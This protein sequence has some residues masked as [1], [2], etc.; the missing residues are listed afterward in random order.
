MHEDPRPSRRNSLNRLALV[1]LAAA[2][3]PAAASTVQGAPLP[4]HPAASAPDPAASASAK[5]KSGVV[6]SSQQ[7]DINHAT[8]ERLKTLPG[9]G[10][11]EAARIVA[12]RPYFSK[13]DLVTKQVLSEGSYAAIKYRVFAAPPA[14]KTG[15]KQ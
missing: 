8:R 4:V 6:P 2:A 11:A 15:V 13:A 7:I 14:G 5:H 9:I 3:L 1:V 10:D 12:G